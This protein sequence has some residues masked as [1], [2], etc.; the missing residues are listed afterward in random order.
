[1]EE[2]YGIYRD[3]L[4]CVDVSVGRS[5]VTGSNFTMSGIYEKSLET[6]SGIRTSAGTDKKGLNNRN[7]DQH[8]A[9]FAGIDS[10]TFTYAY[11]G[12]SASEVEIINQRICILRNLC[13][14]LSIGV[15]GRINEIN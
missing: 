3:M 7:H 14:D 2:K 15:C 13:S 10:L 8:Y 12:R 11:A 5:L 1:M 9:D 4:R 6:R